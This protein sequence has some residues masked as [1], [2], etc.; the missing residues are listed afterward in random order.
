MFGLFKP[1]KSTSIFSKQEVVAAANAVMCWK[2]SV[3]EAASTYDGMRLGR[4]S[5]IPWS[6]VA[7]RFIKKILQ[8]GPFS[9]DDKA[10]IEQRMNMYL[11][12]VKMQALDNSNYFT[13]EE[14][15][16]IG[17]FIAIATVCGIKMA[18]LSD[19]E[20]A[21]LVHDLLPQEWLVKA[22]LVPERFDDTYFSITGK[23]RRQREIG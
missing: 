22:G 4:L 18:I 7:N 17:E 10:Q 23:K 3:D 12:F 2:L 19:I 5:I 16:T 13:Q 9:P 8:L 6:D 14:L 11:S 15:E 20:R 1:K 21:A